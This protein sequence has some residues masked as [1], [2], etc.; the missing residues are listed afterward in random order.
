MPAE[1]V[2]VVDK[3]A[4]VQ[5]ITKGVLE[6]HGYRVTI[7]SNGLAALVNPDIEKFSLILVDSSLEGLDGLETTRQI[8]TDKGTHKIPVLLL[9]PE[10]SVD[11]LESVPLKGATGWIAKPFTSNKLVSKVREIIEEQRLLVLSEQY[12][13]E[14]AESHMQ[15]LAEKKIQN[16]VE[17]KIQIIVERAIQ[18]IVSIID[19]RARREVESRV[20]ALSAEKEQQLVKMTVQE[21]AHSMVEKLAERKVSEAMDKI[22]VEQTER[23]VKRAIDAMLPSIMRERLREQIENTL[24]REVETRVTKA[25]EERAAEIGEHL[26]TIITEQSR[27]L[28][29]LV[30]KESLPDLAERQMVAV[31]ETQLPRIIQ[32]QSKAALSR[33]IE[34]NV[35][36]LLAEEMA[37]MRRQSRNITIAGLVIILVMAII[38]FIA[39]F[40]LFS[41][42]TERAAQMNAALPMPPDT[43][44][45]EHTALS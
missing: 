41:Q 35:R 13:M 22:L 4:A 14:A 9:I 42:A 23:T 5:D 36:P 17:K 34:T 3:S 7:A 27:K 11:L 25:A 2:L 21:V 30:A 24:P 20:T 6:E 10:D 44:L 28:V 31:A 32:E 26:V 8:K 16:A 40:I 33:E 43:V 18:S 39:A 19:Q 38:G 15:A 1:R 37:K 29:P 12:L 45:V